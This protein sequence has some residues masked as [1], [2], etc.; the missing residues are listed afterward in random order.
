MAGE[1]PADWDAHVAAVLAKVVDKAETI[2]TRKAS[3]NS[4][5]AYAPKL[6][7]LLGGSADLAGSNLTLW[8]GAKGV[9]K[10]NGGN[11]VYYGVR[12]FGM[13]AIANG[14]SL[15]GG[16]IPYTATFLMFSEYAR[17]AL[18]MAALMKIR[19]IFVFTHDSIGLGE[20]GPTHQ[21]VEQIA[22]LRLIPNM[23][24]WRPCDSTES[25]VA[26]ACAIERKSGP[27]SLCFS[28][29]NLP[30]QTRSAEQLADIR[31]GG[32]VLAEANGTARA[33]ILATGSEV[34]L[35]LAARQ[36]LAEAGIA[37]RVVSMPST[38]VFDRQDEAYRAAVLPKGLPRV[39]VEAGVSDGWRKYVGLEGE[40]VGIDRFGE[41]APAGELFKY[42]GIT[43]EAVVAA[44][45]KALA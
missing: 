13:A 37:V 3:Q 34:T 18:R 45:R 22:T 26:W 39:A 15:H 38:N 40:V 27:S 7:E 14:I 30:F 17:N 5:E 32:Y 4:I 31:R 19:Q 20:D 8:S 12:E 29:Q 9:S 16:L 42:F 28:R 11:Y 6:P 44:V 21:P 23:D 36:Q 33:V 1:L 10:T 25:A 24:V 2:A 41:S 35:A 43:T